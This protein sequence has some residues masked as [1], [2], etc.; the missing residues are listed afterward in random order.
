MHE[1]VNAKILEKWRN[2]QEGKGQ[3]G[4]RDQFAP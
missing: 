2:A 4:N 1:G 3:S